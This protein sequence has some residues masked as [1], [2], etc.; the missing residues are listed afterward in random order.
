MLLD[1]LVYG[2]ATGVFS[3]RKLARGD[4]DWV[5][6]EAWKRILSRIIKRTHEGR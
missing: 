3:S 2:Y 1:V 4:L 6:S 5:W